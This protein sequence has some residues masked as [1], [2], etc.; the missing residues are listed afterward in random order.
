MKRRISVQNLNASTVDILNVIRKNAGQEYQDLVPEISKS[1]E[2]PKVGEVLFGY[3]ALANQFISA[4]INRIAAVRVKSV[5]FNDPMNK[6]FGKGLLEY[7]ETVEEIFVQIANVR[8]FDYDKAEKRELKRT[9]PDIRSALHTMSWNVQY[10][11]TVTDTDLRKA[12]LSADGVT[13]LI[14]RI[15]DS[16]YKAAE[17]DSYLLYKYL[18]IKTISHGKIVSQVV[19]NS[20]DIEEFAIAFRATSNKLTIP[21]REYNA[22]NVL[23]NTDKDKQYLC[24]DANFAARY[25]VKVLA[26]AFNMSEADYTSKVVLIDNWDEFDNDRFDAIRAESDMIDEVTPE[27]LNAMKKVRG[28]LVDEWFFQ[29]YDNAMKMTETFVAAGDYWNYFYRVQKTISYSPFANAIAFVTSDAV[30]T[31][32]ESLT[33]KITDKSVSDVATIFTLA[34][35]DD[36]ATLHNTNVRFIQT[37][38]A[39]RAAIAIHEYGAVIMPSSAA[40]VTLEL[41]M[42]GATYKASTPT[43]SAANVG[44]TI[45]FAKQ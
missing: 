20:D 13:D 10:P 35:Q 33:V 37:E 34:V 2:I 1:S 16:I 36:D 17:Y 29:C 32:P 9:M 38:E 22:A 28:V 23:T 14:A 39:T 4:L 6:R 7:G 42:G 41:E 45:T 5:T 40:S 26:S 31:L 8:V 21:R 27:E 24:L 25:S 30:V 12:F 43:T 44:E 3:P 15:V 18:L 11:V 19:P